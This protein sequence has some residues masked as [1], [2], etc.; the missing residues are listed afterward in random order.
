MLSLSSELCVSSLVNI[1]EHV[2]VIEKTHHIK[3][4]IVI[5]LVIF[6]IFSR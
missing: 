1:N 2:H 5:C 4:E 3:S 6:I